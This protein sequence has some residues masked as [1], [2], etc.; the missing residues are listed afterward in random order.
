MQCLKKDAVVQGD[1]NSSAGQQL[2]IRFERCVDDPET[3]VEERKCK[4]EADILD[5]IQRKFIVTLE[6]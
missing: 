5:W 2:V 4:A 3:P 6:N 1:Y